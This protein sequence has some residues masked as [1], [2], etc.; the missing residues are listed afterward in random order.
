MCSPEALSLST[1]AHLVGLTD[2]FQNAAH[3]IEIGNLPAHLGQ[4]IRVEA[5]LPGLTAGIIYIQNP[6]PMALAA[7]AS[8][9]E[10][11]GGME[12]VAFQ[13][14]AAQQIVQRWELTQ[15]LVPAGCSLNHLYRC[16]KYFA[17]LSIHFLKKIG[18]AILEHAG[19]PKR[20]PLPTS[21]IWSSTREPICTL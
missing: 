15:E 17:N 12:S 14:R 16:Y 7:G 19:S 13:E 1:Q 21:A 11:S 5:D 2:P 8:R 18:T 6:L 4:L 9:A 10:D 3:S 20:H